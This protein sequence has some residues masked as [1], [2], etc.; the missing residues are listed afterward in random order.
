MFCAALGD[1]H[2]QWR[3][4]MTLIEWACAEAGILS[5]DLAAI[6]QVGDAE[7]LR[8]EAEISQ[9]P[10]PCGCDVDCSSSCRVF[11]G[12]PESKDV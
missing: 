5:Q 10:G 6:F 4:A 12:C 9:V 1:V 2:G 7:A 3:E 11:V 8:C